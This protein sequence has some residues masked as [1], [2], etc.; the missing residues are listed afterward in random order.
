VV[1]GIFHNI[2][3]NTLLCSAAMYVAGTDPQVSLDSGFETGNPCNCLR[4]M[5]ACPSVILCLA[6]PTL[7]SPLLNPLL[8]PCLPP[9]LPL[10]QPPDH[11]SEAELI[12][13]MEKHGIGTDASI[14]THI[15]NICE[16]NY[17]QV[18][19]GGGGEGGPCTVSSSPWKEGAE[20]GESG[21]M[22]PIMPS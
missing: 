4:G 6:L 12:G 11:L 19:L 18:S 3:V 7:S 5:H 2:T 16:R 13:L 20:E 17:V 10:L 15:N 9:P 22:G 21:M 14:P 1:K 8:P